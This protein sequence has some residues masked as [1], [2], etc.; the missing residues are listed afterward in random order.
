MEPY[1]PH[2]YCHFYWKEEHKM[3]KIIIAT[4][5]LLLAACGG[6]KTVYVT[7]T[8]PSET[9]P[10]TTTTKAP[11]PTLPPSTSSPW[12]AD[13]EFLYDVQ[14]S[15]NGTIYIAEYE[16]IKTAKIVCDSLLSGM[17]GEQVLWAILDAGGDTEF[18]TALV[19]AAVIN[20]CPSQTYKFENL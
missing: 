9:E 17:S 11:I 1:S 15:Y 12:T 7:E 3:K 8:T 18:L 10:L 13:D 19:A 5:I 2:D 16:M 14:S 20:Y 4:T 6:T